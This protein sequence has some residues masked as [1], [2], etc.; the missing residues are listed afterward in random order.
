MSDS[1]D[2]MITLKEE[3]K[4]ENDVTRVLKT[5][6]LVDVENVG[7]AWIDSITQMNDV[8][9]CL[10]FTA[11]CPSISYANLA[12]ILNARSNVT[13]FQCDP[14]P[15][16]ADFQLASYLGYLISSSADCD[17]FV[18]VSNDK[19]FDCVCSFWN[20]QGH[21]VERHPLRNQAVQPETEPLPQNTSQL[22]GSNQAIPDEVAEKKAIRK[23][24]RNTIKA[25]LPMDEKVYTGEILNLIEKHKTDN[26]QVIYRSF[27]STFGQ[28]K[29]LPRY[30]HVKSVIKQVQTLLKSQE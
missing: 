26:L 1:N 7:N 5:C 22:N 12:A 20:K 23:K 21:R 3:L 30:N 6:Y 29:G 8:R 15:N 24:C 27:I 13:C 4:T 28:K 9:I 14:G 10:F 17:R 18:I 2:E 19:G 16:A 11:H 25:C